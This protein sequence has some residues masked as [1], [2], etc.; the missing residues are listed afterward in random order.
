[1]KKIK[2]HIKIYTGLMT[3][4]KVLPITTEKV[5]SYPYP[6]HN[7]NYDTKQNYLAVVDTYANNNVFICQLSELSYVEVVDEEEELKNAFMD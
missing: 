3:T 7:I 2:I 4:E 6:K 5:L 1:M